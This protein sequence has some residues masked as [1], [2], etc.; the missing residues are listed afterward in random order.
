VA[1]ILKPIMLELGHEFHTFCVG[2]PGSPDVT[3]AQLI[4]D[5]IGSTH[6]VHLFNPEEAFSVIPKVIYHL[7]TYEPELIRSAIPNYFLAKMTS[8]HTK[9]V[10]T[11][12]GADE[13]FAGYL[14][15]HG[16]AAAPMF[17]VMCASLQSMPSVLDPPPLL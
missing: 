8:Q 2:C 16:N 9:V 13:L 6:H 3:S 15:F 14:Y 11:G 4:A 7:E 10:L 5:H 12:E 1:T 17:N